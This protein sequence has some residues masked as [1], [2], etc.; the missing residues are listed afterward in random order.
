MPPRSPPLPGPLLV[1]KK[2]V[3]ADC[4]KAGGAAMTASARQAGEIS[5]TK[6]RIRFLPIVLVMLQ[7]DQPAARVNIPV[8]HRKGDGPK[9]K[10]R[11][12]AAA[13]RIV[14]VVRSVGLLDRREFPV[15]AAM[16]G[17]GPHFRGLGRLIAAGN[18]LIAVAVKSLVD[19]REA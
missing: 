16:A 12:F 1:R 4:A 3:P 10:R 13:L 15:A 9:Q 11:G 5:L 17:E 19:Q 8:S 18:H 6:V 2:L 7:P 14:F